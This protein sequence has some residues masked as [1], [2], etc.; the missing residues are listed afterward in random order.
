MRHYLLF[1]VSICLCAVSNIFSVTHARCTGLSG[2]HY[3]WLEGAVIG[4]DFGRNPWLRNSTEG[5]AGTRGRSNLHQ[6]LLRAVEAGETAM[7]FD[8]AFDLRSIVIFASDGS[9]ALDGFVLP[10][11]DAFLQ[12]VE[13]A[14]RAARRSG[15]YFRAEVVLFDFRVA[16][17]EFVDEGVRGE[18]PQLFTSAGE[19]RSLF[20]ALQPALRL[21]GRHRLVDLNL[22]NEPEFLALPVAKAIARIE[23]G[24]WDDISFVGADDAGK[25]VVVRGMASLPMLAALGAQAHVRVVGTGRKRVQKLVRSSLSVAE[26]DNF[27]LDLRVAIE[28]V[29]P[30]AQVMV[31]WSDDRSAMENTLRLEER[32]GAPI[33][34]I[35]SFHVYQVPINPWHPLKLTRADFA[36]VGLGGGKIRVGEF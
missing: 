13:M 24:E 7:S 1:V 22:M 26:L 9:V 35:I 33:S 31:G 14:D 20:I 21:L 25:I 29:A 32:A 3:S 18:Y 19:R 4:H 36:A 30:E 6:A 23:S 16:D 15:G 17:G 10:A 12:E 34:E 27:L 2:H 11:I 8:I 5:F 28:E